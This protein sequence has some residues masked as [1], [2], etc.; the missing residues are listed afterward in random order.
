MSI[1]DEGDELWN[2]FSDAM[3]ANAFKL[4]DAEAARRPH[5]PKCFIAAMFGKA[6]VTTGASFLGGSVN[7][8][9]EAALNLANSW[10]RQFKLGH[11]HRN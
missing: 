3:L 2:L 9:A 6:M 8:D 4:M 7:M 5:L 10:L 1:E 11:L